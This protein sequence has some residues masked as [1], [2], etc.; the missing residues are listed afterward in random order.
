M[1]AGVIPNE[2]ALPPK[3]TKSVSSKHNLK[4][5]TR[6]DKALFRPR[7]S[8]RTIPSQSQAYKPIRKRKTKPTL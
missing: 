5:R 8:H 3:N 1:Q 7:Q 2:L 4:T 6:G